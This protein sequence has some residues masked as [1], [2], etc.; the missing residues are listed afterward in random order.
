MD[1]RVVEPRNHQ[2]PV[3]IDA[4]SCLVPSYELITP[5]GHDPAALNRHGRPDTLPVIGREYLAVMEQEIDALALG[6]ERH[7]K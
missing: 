2:T 6:G 1:V 7:G 4:S 5:D 3:E